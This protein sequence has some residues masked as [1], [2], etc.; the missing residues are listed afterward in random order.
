[1]NLDEQ[2]LK[3]TNGDLAQLDLDIAQKVM[4]WHY[5]AGVQEFTPSRYMPDAMRVAE[6]MQ[7]NGWS[8]EIYRDYPDPEW[9]ATF[10]I[11]DPDASW[12]TTRSASVDSK[13]LPDAICRAAIAALLRNQGEI[14]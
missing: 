12:I 9:N 11:R 1:M 4:G 8:V 14:R 7:E 2:I 6:K 3:E 13:S 5:R 10:C